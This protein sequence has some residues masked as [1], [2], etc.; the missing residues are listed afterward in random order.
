MFFLGPGADAMTDEHEGY[1]AGRYR[2]DSLSDIWTDVTRC[3]ELTFIGYLPRCECGWI[4]TDQTYSDAGFRQCQQ[5]WATQHFIPKVL[6]QVRRP[7]SSGAAS[8]LPSADF[9][10]NLDQ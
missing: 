6:P 1:V 3:A 4:G 5:D 10:F 7:V 9:D 8:R 2:D